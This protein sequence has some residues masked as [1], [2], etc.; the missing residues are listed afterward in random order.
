MDEIRVEI[1]PII[2][3]PPN[4]PMDSAIFESWCIGKLKAAGI[5]IKGVLV[6]K[7]LKSGTLTRHENFDRP[8]IMCFVWRNS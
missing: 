8:H 1:N 4:M 7:G 2:D 3:Y 5:P 6:F